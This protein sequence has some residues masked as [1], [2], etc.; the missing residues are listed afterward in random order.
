M[1]ARVSAVRSCLPRCETCGREPATVFS[2][3]TDPDRWC[4]PRS[5]AWKFTGTCTGDRETYY[6]AIRGHGR[7][8]LDSLSVRVEWIRHLSEKR[9]F[10]LSDFLAMLAR[11]EAERN[12]APPRGR[13]V[14][15][16]HRQLLERVR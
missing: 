1:N 7:G 15:G 14:A 12:S 11:F 16:T 13:Q 3:F 6:L 9:W 5:G 10:D 4:E 2:W 8:F